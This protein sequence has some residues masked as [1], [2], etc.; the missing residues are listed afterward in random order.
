MPQLDFIW[1]IVNFFLIWTTITIA[2]IILTNN[3]SPTNTT[4]NSINIILN[5]ETTNWQWF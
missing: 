2:F 3:I 1:W 4:E 5:N